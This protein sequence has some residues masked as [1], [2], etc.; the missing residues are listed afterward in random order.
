MKS[1]RGRQGVKKNLLLFAYLLTEFSDFKFFSDGN[2]V[3]FQLI[4]LLDLHGVYQNCHFFEI[5]TTFQ[6]TNN[7]L[8]KQFYDEIFSF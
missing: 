6:L 1:T 2:L 5:H 3:F 7:I 4:T 8:N